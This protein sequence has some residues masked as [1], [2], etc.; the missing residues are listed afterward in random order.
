[1]V[2]VTSMTTG[3][4]TQSRD[5]S[6]Y[7]P[8]PLCIREP[9]PSLYT[10]STDNPVLDTGSSSSTISSSGACKAEHRPYPLLS[11]EAATQHLRIRREP[12]SCVMIFHHKRIRT[13]I[14]P[15]LAGEVAAKPTE[16]GFIMFKINK[17]N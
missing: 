1:M 2:A 4:K 13:V 17:I 10:L 5:G 16:G 7:Q 11:F 15:P 3:V 8:V 9:A 14:L 6:S 12:N